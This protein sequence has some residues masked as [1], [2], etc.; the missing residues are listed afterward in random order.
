[1]V[2]DMAMAL[3]RKYRPSR[4]DELDQEKVRLFFERVLASGQVAQA[5]L[6]TGPKGTGKTSAARILAAI[7]NCEENIKRQ[8]EGQPEHTG[9]HEPCGKCDSC[10]EIRS[11]SSTSVTEIDAA[12]NRGIDDVRIL[13]ERVGLAAPG[14]RHSVFIIDEVHMLTREAFNALLKTLEEPPPKVLFCLCTTEIHKL[15]E[16]VTSRCTLVNYVRANDQE[17]ERSL[18]RVIRGEKIQIE[19]KAIGE[20]ASRS[21]GSFR[22]AVMILERLL[23][24]D[25][26]IQ[27]EDVIREMG[28]GGL[29]ADKQLY[30]LIK[31]GEVKSALAVLEKLV[32]GGVEIKVL[33]KRILA[34]AVGELKDRLLE[35]GRVDQNQVR[36]IEVISKTFSRF[37][38]V[39]IASLPLEMAIVEYGLNLG[40]V[41]VSENEDG[42]KPRETKVEENDKREKISRKTLPARR[43]IKV[44]KAVSSLMEDVASSPRTDVDEESD[45]MVDKEPL[46]K[47]E[48]HLEIE[49]VK[50]NW[51]KVLKRVEEQNH[52]LVTLLRRASLWRCK[53]NEIWMTVGYKFH[54]EQLEQ[55]R[56]LTVIEQVVEEIYGGRAKLMFEVKAVSTPK[57]LQKHENVSGELPPEDQKLVETIEEVFGV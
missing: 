40:K 35:S 9:L 56:Y 12:S 16:T 6:F 8:K 47:N 34:L 55:D 25:R 26:K 19:E 11:G 52:G 2:R 30:E 7:V 28:E 37:A 10:R 50:E 32:T 14:G 22:D 24:L 23:N 43:E 46:G 57:K 5:Y 17:V 27:V 29:K 4:V 1:M 53:D 49:N 15:P 3:N 33:T 51:G 13:R 18:N 54:K 38:Q 45:V 39:P 41:E 31:K 42:G 21:D 20:I 44:E 48:I 36:L